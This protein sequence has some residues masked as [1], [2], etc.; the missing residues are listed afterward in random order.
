MPIET[1]EEDHSA[2]ARNPSRRDFSRTA[3][4]AAAAIAA[5]ARLAARAAGDPFASLDGV[6]SAGVIRSGQASAADLVET[7]IARIERLNPQ[8]AAVCAPT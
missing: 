6:G 8:L 4:A 5:G 2:Q 1:H 7:A 3:G